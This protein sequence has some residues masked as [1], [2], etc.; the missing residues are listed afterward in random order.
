MSIVPVPGGLTAIVTQEGTLFVAQCME[1]D[2]ASQGA[3]IEASLTNLREALD[4][5]LEGDLPTDEQD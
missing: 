5:Y 2:V 4:L 3:S 1:I